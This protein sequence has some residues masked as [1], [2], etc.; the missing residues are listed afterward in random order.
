VRIQELRIHP[1]TVEA[2]ERLA[3]EPWI[4][5]DEAAAATDDVLHGLPPPG[6]A[7]QDGWVVGVAEIARDV[8]ER[9]ISYGT[10]AR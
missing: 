1:F 6:A 3:S 7:P 5:V 8:C 4:G 2:I 9:G 10:Q